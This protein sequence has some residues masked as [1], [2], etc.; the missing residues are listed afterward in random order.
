[1]ETSLYK[2]QALKFGARYFTL[3]L[4]AL[5]LWLMAAENEQRVPSRI[6]NV[7]VFLSQAQVTRVAKVNLEAGIT[8]IV[9]SQASPF[10]IGNSIQVKT[11]SNVNLISVATQHNYLKSE[12]KPED[13]LKLE[14]SLE[15]IAGQL[16]HLKAKK[17]A[18]L[19]KKDLLNTNKHLGGANTGLHTDDLEDALA[20]YQ[21]H[22]EEISNELYKV[23]KAEKELQL[24]QAKLKAQWDTYNTQQE[25]SL[26]LV[27]TVQT[28]TATND[29]PIEFSYLVN[30]ASWTP[31]Y[32]IRVKNSK[33]PL[34]LVNKAR[35]TQNT[36][37]DWTEAALTLSTANP[38]ENGV[39]PELNT[40]FI[41]FLQPVTTQ[42]YAPRN[43][44]MESL[45]VQGDK[46][47]YATAAATVN[48]NAVNT[49]FVVNNLYTIPSD[50]Q[51]HLVD[52]S[53][54]E[55]NASYNYTAVPKLESNVFATASIAAID[56]VNQLEGEAYVYYDGSF[57]G[58]SYI[59]RTSN[60]TL[61]I[62]LGKDK[63]IQIERKLVKELSSRTCLSGSKKEQT[64][65]E[66]K[67]KNTRNEPFKIKIEDQIP[68]STD[69]EI[70]VTLTDA[71]GATYDQQ[72][73][74]LNWDL[75][76]DAEKSAQLKFTFEVKYPKNK[77]ITPY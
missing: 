42:S 32:E 21:K 15:H 69:K 68:V 76:L 66:I 54:T 13:I 37:E 5:P 73:G 11:A 8:S 62:T 47:V 45:D 64:T 20:L 44:A 7:T 65:W 71:G 60:D 46:V 67:V 29:A 18:L 10:L 23:E 34:Q 63:R 50:N 51:S 31:F 41:G 35:I 49:E 56:L 38:N 22:T 4:F 55:Y 9:F 12:Q 53:V 1:M 43:K 16:A 52:L 36:G 39:K 77:A 74:K 19:S 26:E 25:Q 17:E 30:N 24:I 70:E 27:V 48:Q 3:L 28:E 57:I 2:Y 58:T 61:I 14:D 75:T 59:E 72:T 40:H 6:S 33:S